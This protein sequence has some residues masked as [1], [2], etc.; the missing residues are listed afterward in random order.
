MPVSIVWLLC[1]LVRDIWKYRQANII[2]HE[3]FMSNYGAGVQ[4][5]H[6]ARRRHKGKKVMATF[7]NEPG[8]THNL[9][10]GLIFP[11]IQVWMLRKPCFVFHIDGRK[12]RLPSDEIFIPI[13]E[14]ISNFFMSLFASATDY[15]VHAEL[16]FHQQIPPHLKDEIPENYGE[17]PAAPHRYFA[18][19]WCGHL[20]REYKDPSMARL[21]LPEPLRREIHEKLKA[22]RHGREAHLCMS[23]NKLEAVA[24]SARQGSTMEDYL[25]SI[26]MLVAQGYQ[27]LLAGDRSLDQSQMDDFDGMVVD[28]RSLGVEKDIFRLFVP[29][30]ADICIGDAG[31]GIL[32]PLI[33]GMPIL[34]LNYYPFG[35]GTP[36]RWVYPKKYVDEAGNIIPYQRVIEENPF[37]LY[38]QVRKEPL[39]ISP[40][41]NSEEEITE[42]VECFL[43][44]LVSPSDM[45][46][47]EELMGLIPKI[48]SFYS[49]GSR[50]SPAFIR[51][52]QMIPRP[53]PERP[54]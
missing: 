9:K 15:E 54:S 31:A 48:S 37:G 24:D 46:P 27:V 7:L 18:A 45:I 21:R 8:S 49:Y 42:A 22:T 44:D 38:E 10:L 26:R 32:L 23:Y 5:T 35:C 14:A 12:Y 19:L 11:D 34:V 28:A 51:R 25:P 29:T 41:C 53:G 30:E 4:S 47:G 13:K 33:V 20:Q 3:V 6:T 50:F 43:E 52:N 16:A 40:V 36:G 17:D 1:Q 39:R 2:F